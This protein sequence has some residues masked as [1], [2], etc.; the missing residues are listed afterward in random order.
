T[1]E[2][3]TEYLDLIIFSPFGQ[4]DIKSAANLI[5]SVPDATGGKEDNLDSHF[6]LSVGKP[7]LP[8]LDGSESAAYTTDELQEILDRKVENLMIN[9][10]KDESVAADNEILLVDIKSIDEDQLE[11][12]LDKDSL[13]KS[14]EVDDTIRSSEQLKSI[15]WSFGKDLTNQ[16][17][18]ESL[19]LDESNGTNKETPA[20]SEFEDRKWSDAESE[21]NLDEESIFKGTTDEESSAAEIEVEDNIKQ[22]TDKTEV[23]SDQSIQ[24]EDELDLSSKGDV[25]SSEYDERELIDEITSEESD[26]I[27]NLQTDEKIEDSIDVDKLTD[28]LLEDIDLTD[29]DIEMDD[30]EV[31]DNDEKMGKFEIVRSISSSFDESKSIKDIEGFDNFIEDKIDIGKGSIKSKKGM[32]DIDLTQENFEPAKSNREEE[33]QIPQKTPVKKKELKLNRVESK[34][35]RLQYDRKNS[36]V[37]FLVIFAVIAGIV[38]VIYLLTKSDSDTEMFEEVTIPPSTTEN[39][40]YIERTYDIPVNYPYEKSGADLEVAGLG[41]PPE[42]L[43]DTESEENIVTT[44]PVDEDLI[45]EDQPVVHAGQRPPGTPVQA[46]YNIFKYG[47]KFV[48]Q[49][50]AFNSAG[51][52][53]DEVMRYASQGYNSFIERAY[54][55]GKLW[56]RVRVGNFNSLDEAKQF[57]TSQQ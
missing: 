15:A 2:S 27:M 51:T 20:D 26:E 45:E 53:Q 35:N 23:S 49:V 57:R 48:V 30:F 34:R 18:D 55:D 10:H 54:I 33:D 31:T 8:N 43:A 19:S 5:F 47:N 44:K 1:G 32:E 56:Y 12:E 50:S 4:L 28:Q 6:S 7:V 9:L 40:T 11:L 38:G 41:P 17:K 24:S 13:N 16:I 22:V 21:I 36:T 46:A 39:T 52:A 25:L 14:Q 3:H 29:L 42:P 37:K